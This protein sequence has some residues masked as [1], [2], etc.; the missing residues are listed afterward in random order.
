MTTYPFP[1]TSSKTDYRP[2]P[3]IELATSRLTLEAV[4]QSQQ[5]LPAYALVLGL[6]ADQLPLV[7]DL[8]EPTSGAFLIASDSGF[9]N[10]TLLHS[11]LTSA[12]LLNTEAEVNIHLISPQADS[13]RRFHNQP[14][15]KIS[16]QPERRECEI[17]L[18]EMT[19]LIESRQQNRFPQPIH[20]LFIDS[21]DILW[22]ALSPQGR[23]WLD[24]ITT[25]GP[26][27]GLW[28]FASLETDYLHPELYSL[29]DIFPSRVL[30]SIRQPGK[31]SY[32]SGLNATDLTKLTPH[33]EYVAFSDGQSFNIQLLPAEDD[34]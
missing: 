31:A 26:Q 12:F 22:N 30:G 25:Y 33:L 1:T 21:L 17:V 6:C 4:L 3:H 34:R 5:I 27:H 32:L 18:E 19:S 8:T 20:V 10:T 14:N 16:F 9:A 2:A 24:W 29:V 7:L 23:V 11:I 15:F 28:V 13:L